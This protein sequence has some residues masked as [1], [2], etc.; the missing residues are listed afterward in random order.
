MNRKG[1]RRKKKSEK[2]VVYYAN[3]R[4]IQSK[5]SCIEDILSEAK[6]EL[7]LMTETQLK[8]NVGIKFEGYRFFGRS[9]SEKSGGGVGILVKDEVSHSVAPHFSQREIEIMWLSIRRK[10]RS[11]VHFGIYYG[12]QESRTNKEEI[13]YEMDLLHEEITEMKNEGEVML[14]M[15]GNGKI[16]LLGKKI[17]K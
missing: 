7:L 14:L 8:N 9:R 12:K 6:P 2:W 17:K 1:L 13:E 10:N 4:G 5:R 3:V 11:P 16:G 15:D